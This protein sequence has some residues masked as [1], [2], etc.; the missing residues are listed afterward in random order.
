[1]RLITF[2]GAGWRVI[3]VTPRARLQTVGRLLQTV[4]WAMATMTSEPIQSPTFQTAIRLDGQSNY[5][6]NVA[7]AVFTLFRKKKQY[8]AAYTA[9]K[10]RDI[11]PSHK[12]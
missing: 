4:S 11:V 9:Y 10:Q 3:L 1:M 6:Y 2:L 5:D 12:R 7:I 8:L